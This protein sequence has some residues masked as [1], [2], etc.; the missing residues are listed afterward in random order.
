MPPLRIILQARTTSTRLP[1]KALLPVAGYPSAV[2]A[3]LRGAN[4]GHELLVATSDHVSDDGLA[5]IFREHGFKVFRGPLNDVLA[6]YYLA[7]S[8]L[9][10]DATV[11]RL[12]GDNTLPDGEFVQ[13]V[14]DSFV[15]ARLEYLSVTSPQSRLPH[16]LFAEAFTAKA[17]RTAHHNA[18]EPYDREHVGPWMGRNSLAENYIPL[19]VRNLDYSHLYCS[20]DTRDD[21]DRIVRVFDGVPAP[22]AATWFELMEKLSSVSFPM[23]VG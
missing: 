22:V 17:L 21:Y 7:A 10:D 3:A 13:E 8:D 20:I 9:P 14:A 2:L 15:R 19:A 18:T 6:R 4:R 5:G 1:G 11:V 12:T 16:G 23:Q